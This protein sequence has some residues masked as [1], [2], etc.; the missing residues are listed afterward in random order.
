MTTAAAPDTAG[1]PAPRAGEP[2]QVPDAPTVAVDPPPVSPLAPF[3][4]G[5]APLLA[6]GLVAAGLP[7]RPVLLGAAA[8]VV[9]LGAVLDARGQLLGVLPGALLL[10]GGA[11]AL[12]AGALHLGDAG[13]LVPAGLLA[14]WAGSRLQTPG[15]PL[16]GRASGVVAGVAVVLAVGLHLLLPAPPAPAPAPA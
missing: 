9:L 13:V 2:D 14:A 11:G 3:L 12:A 10:A 4:S 8:G 1:V 5:L 7:D 6:A 15:A 16:L